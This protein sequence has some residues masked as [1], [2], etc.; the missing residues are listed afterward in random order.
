MQ[1]LCYSYFCV[2]HVAF[3]QNLIYICCANNTLM[4]HFVFWF[5]FVKRILRSSRKDKK[6]GKKIKITKLSKRET[7]NALKA[8][9]QFSP[10]FLTLQYLQY[11][12]RNV[13]LHA[14]QPAFQFCL[15]PAA[16]KKGR[17]FATQQCKFRQLFRIVCTHTNTF[18][19]ANSLS[20]LYFSTISLN[21]LSCSRC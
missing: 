15:L 8:N 2:T 7:E 14:R 1:H 6:F 21:N 16:A 18:T 17:K 12:C 9:K 20:C 5:L 10:T 4:L 19:L 3:R 13:M 11:M